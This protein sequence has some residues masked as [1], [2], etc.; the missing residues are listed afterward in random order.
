MNNCQPSISKLILQSFCCQASIAKLLLPAFYCQASNAKLL[1]QSFYKPSFY[2]QAS[3]ASLLYCQHSNAPFQ[4]SPSP[5]CAQNF[6]LLNT[7]C[8]EPWDGT[9]HPSPTGYSPWRAF[10]DPTPGDSENMQ[11][12]L[13][14]PS[15]RMQYLLHTHQS[16]LQ[17]RRG[18]QQR[19]RHPRSS[20]HWRP[21]PRTTPSW[22]SPMHS[23][24]QLEKTEFTLWMPY[25]N[26]SSSKWKPT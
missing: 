13:S 23:K 10:G 26:N 9:H 15:T 7:S 21:P 5:L 1:L 6:N 20:E 2:C 14:L 8:K 11:R 3:I 16:C 22:S 12:E 17:P 25:T 4:D 18:S 19:Q 24:M